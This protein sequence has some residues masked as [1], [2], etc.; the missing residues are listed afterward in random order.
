[1]ALTNYLT[2]VTRLLQNPPASPNLYTVSDLT[3]YINVARNQLAV[4]T[5]CVRSNVGLTLSGSQQQYPLSSITP[6]GS[7]ISAIVNVQ[8][9][10]YASGGGYVYLNPRQWTYF[11][12]FM[13]CVPSVPT[14]APTDWTQYSTGANGV[15]Y[16]NPV[17]NTT[18]NV[19]LDAV[20][21]PIPLVNDATVEAIPYPY[22]DAV[23][24]FA[25]YYAYMS[26]QRGADADAMFARYKEFV[27]RAQMASEPRTPNS[28]YPSL[29]NQTPAP[30]GQAG[31]Q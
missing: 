11:N 22:T 31:A 19:L 24:F 27:F 4:E 5:M 26:A 6:S 10:Y 30:P 21:T 17:P 20:C 16:F 13:L 1:M 3:Y 28:P 15:L 2:Q 23:P 7:G 25:A 9:A 18:F 12:V 8:T 29:R 14:G